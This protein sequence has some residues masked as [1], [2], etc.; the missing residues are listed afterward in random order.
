[1]SDSSNPNYPNS[2]ADI[3]AEIKFDLD[4]DS[5]L[6]EAYIASWLRGAIGQLNNSIGTSYVI[7]ENLEF[8]P[9]ISNEAKDIFK[10]L[11]ICRY[12][13]IQAKSQ[14]GAS[15]YSWTEVRENDTV[16]RR[17]SNN[18]IAK[19]F[20][21]LSKQ[22]KESLSQIIRYYKTNRALPV[23]LSSATSPQTVTTRNEA[24]SIPY[25]WPL[26]YYLP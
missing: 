26:P 22:C 2:V 6:S 25:S 11:F 16:F 14:L 12:Y 5:S 24:P 21:Q 20:L 19:T 13:D 18:E 15:A 4:N 17:V 23:S 3:A 7:D 9:C 10:W 1:M 8:S